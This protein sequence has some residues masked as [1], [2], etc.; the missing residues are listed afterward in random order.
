M[1]NI[2]DSNLQNASNTTDKI[3][4]ILSYD[5]INKDISV[6]NKLNEEIPKKFYWA[7]KP[8]ESFWELKTSDTCNSI[9]EFIKSIWWS[10]SKIR[11]YQVQI[12]D[13]GINQKALLPRKL[14]NK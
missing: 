3:T 2:F 14:L 9:I 1:F 5:L 4:H 13:Q 10:D 8:L 7:K 6:Y 11:V 12:L